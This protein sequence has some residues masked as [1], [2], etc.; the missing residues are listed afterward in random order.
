MA[1][2][3]AITQHCRCSMKTV[4]DRGKWMGMP[5]RLYLRKQGNLD[6][7]CGLQL[8]HEG[9]LTLPSVAVEAQAKG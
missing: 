3:L 5:T 7:A 6:L 8:D 4:I 1:S 2:A 9:F